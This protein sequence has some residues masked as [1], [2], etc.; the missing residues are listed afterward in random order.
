V[1]EFGVGVNV[2]V[3]NKTTIDAWSDDCW[4]GKNEL[5]FKK[6]RST[7]LTWGN[8]NGL[9]TDIH[10]MGEP[11]GTFWS[12]YD[13][14]SANGKDFSMGGDSGSF[15]LDSDGQLAGLLFAG[16]EPKFGHEA[17]LRHGYVIPIGSVIDD[18]EAMT[19]GKVSLP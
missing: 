5:V 4:R 16:S 11:K 7:R 10:F 8:I 15:V 2:N 12:A 9:K 19:G 13:I 14:V 6:G 1:L 17:D 18:I 3:I